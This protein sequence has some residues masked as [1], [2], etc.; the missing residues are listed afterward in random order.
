MDDKITIIEGPPP[1]FELVQDIWANGIIESPNLG[2]VVAT[3]LRTFNGAELVERCH[4][5]WRNKL[6]IHLEYRSPEGLNQEA[7]IIAAR[8][9]ES[10]D[11]Q[12]LIL[13]LRLPSD[14]IEIE[15][16][17]GDDDDELDGDESFDDPLD[18]DF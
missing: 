10:D 5:A 3:R 14:E 7:P 11:G 1:T 13:W 4:R 16:H 18:L 9:T 17:Y 8:H 15:F 2:N 6:P 12:L